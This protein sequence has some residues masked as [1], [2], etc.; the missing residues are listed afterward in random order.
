MPETDYT[1]GCPVAPV[2]LDANA[3]LTGSLSSA[4][5]HSRMG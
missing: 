4:G 1:F 2:I 3:G 5:A